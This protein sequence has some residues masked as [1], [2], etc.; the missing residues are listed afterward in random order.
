MEAVSAFLV[1]LFAAAPHVDLT[2]LRL[3]ARLLSKESR[4]EARL[5]VG[6]ALTEVSRELLA[7]GEHR[8]ALE[9]LALAGLVRQRGPPLA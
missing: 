6:D 8:D 1:D 2:F 3:L 9:L 5:I 7:A 4:V